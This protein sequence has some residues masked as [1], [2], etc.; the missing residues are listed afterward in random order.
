M[1]AI[2]I[3]HRTIIHHE[4]LKRN[5]NEKWAGTGS[6]KCKVLGRDLSQ[7]LLSF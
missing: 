3:F 2:G 1:R 4:L 7:R 6:L 5:I